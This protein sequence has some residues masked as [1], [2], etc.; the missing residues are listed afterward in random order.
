MLLVG[1]VVSVEIFCFLFVAVVPSGFEARGLRGFLIFSSFF[2]L[3]SGSGSLRLRGF[4]TFS[5]V[6]DVVVV[7]FLAEIA[8]P[9]MVEF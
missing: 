2:D 9:D 6:L 1:T 3:P 4:L 7:V 5:E 8:P